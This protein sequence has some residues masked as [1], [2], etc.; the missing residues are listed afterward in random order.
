MPIVNHG[1]AHLSSASD[2]VTVAC[3]EPTDDPL[4]D[5]EIRHR[6]TVLTHLRDGARTH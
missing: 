3:M 1:T 5:P 6:V 4:D 2:F